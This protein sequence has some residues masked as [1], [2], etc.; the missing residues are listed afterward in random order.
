[1]KWLALS[2]SFLLS[3]MQVAN[4]APAASGQ[5]AWTARS[6][7]MK[8]SEGRLFYPPTYL[9]A[10][11]VRVNAEDGNPV[12]SLD[13]SGVAYFDAACSETDRLF[14]L[15]GS[16]LRA[17]NPENGEIYWTYQHEG[18][19]SPKLT[20][21][22]RTNAVFITFG[23]RS[24]HVVA[25]QKVSGQKIWDYNAGLYSNIF[26]SDGENYFINRSVD[27][28]SVIDALNTENGEVRW[29]RALNKDNYSVV[30]PEGHIFISGVGTV[31]RLSSATGTDQWTFQA[32]GDW[33]NLE[34]NSS[35]IIYVHES[36]KLNRLDLETGAV[37]W[38]R[39]LE[40]S[41]DAY[42]Q[43]I[44]LNSGDLLVRTSYFLEGKA[45]NT[46][47]E[48]ASGA[49]RWENTMDSLDGSI[50]EDTAQN[51]Y[52]IQRKK[53]YA[54][55]KQNG[56]VRW[57]FDLPADPN[58]SILK[59]HGQGESFYLTY[60]STGKFPPMGLVRLNA[61]DGS[62]VWQQYVGSAFSIVKWDDERVYIAGYMSGEAQAFLR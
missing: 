61:N 3:A 54:F 57:T 48:K 2:F 55:D 4:A 59:I 35:G 8:D 58:Q 16:T 23:D 51:L 9:N 44:L 18:S 30:D 37:L 28:K 29:S 24:E 11:L 19:S 17:I 26:N 56:L 14:L 50:A 22:P 10:S 39:P 1:M 13:L 42:S 7:L 45:V 53:L 33:A 43:T 21:M 6:N 46:Y 34:Y 31:S 15:A 38:S 12:W 36:H 40:N 20:C 62:L 47:L 49:V 41:K 52:Q 25:I 5:V 32:E 27:G 60:G